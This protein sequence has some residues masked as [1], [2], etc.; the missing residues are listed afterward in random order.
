MGCGTKPGCQGN[1][2]AAA[3]GAV[4]PVDRPVEVTPVV[5]VAALTGVMGEVKATGVD[6]LEV[7]PVVVAALDGVKGVGMGI[8]VEVL[9]VP[10]SVSG[11]C[12]SQ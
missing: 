6:V 9:A 11:S 7:P 1:K 8:G 4:V 10:W 12:V 5:E 2:G 3:F